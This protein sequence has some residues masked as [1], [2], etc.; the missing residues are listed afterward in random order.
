M[1]KVNIGIF[2]LG[3]VGT[4]VLK[5]FQSNQ[6][7]LE[8]KAG[9]ELAI[10]KI[11]DIDIKTPR[12][13]INLNEWRLTEDAEEI[14]NDLNIDIVVELIGGY[15]PPKSYILK[16]IKNRKHIVT[17]N[18]ALL[19]LHGDEIFGA[20]RQ[21]GVRVG[22]EASVAG[23]IPII[24]AIREGLNANKIQSIYGIVNGTCNYILTKMTN[25]GGEFSTIL[26]EA[27]AKGYAEANPIY[28][29]EGIDSAHKIQILSSLAF[30]FNVNFNDIYI[31]GIEKIT[32]QDI[33]F[34]REFGYR[35]KLLAIAKRT[36]SELEVRVHPTMIPEDYPLSNV[37]GI[38]NAIYINGDAIGSMMFFGK[39]A[40]EMPT[41]SA[42]W[43]DII[44][45]AK[46]ISHGLP[47]LKL[48]LPQ[49]ESP[50]IFKIRTIEDIKC[51]YY[52]CFFAIDK[53]GVLS[54]ISGVLGRHNISISSVIQKGRKEQASVPVV[55]MT[56]EAS[57]KDMRKA[58]VEINKLPIVTQQTVLIR[59]EEM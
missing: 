5:I 17:A 20:A 22:F 54:S 46:G 52:L 36:D 43:S 14:I 35:I 53:P 4:G 7:T 50:D 10:K 27:Q 45:I 23:G 49:T 56:H 59:V 8:H 38:F 13:G 55:M 41:A 33:A 19:A 48:D 34:A 42:V 21:E 47:V 40:G 44:D 12:K 9:C 30:G 11:A 32:A 6:S 57:E 18:K 26:A 28:D 2:G 24:R 31:E 58:L 16:A 15:E 3:T 51:P 25:E 39:G 29:V 1:S 37:G